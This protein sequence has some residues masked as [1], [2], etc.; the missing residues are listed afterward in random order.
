MPAEVTAP[1]A[2]FLCLDDGFLDLFFLIPKRSRVKKEASN[3]ELKAKG[4]VRF[5]AAL[6]IAL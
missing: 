1:C 5:P 4:Q 6:L 3:R 2:H